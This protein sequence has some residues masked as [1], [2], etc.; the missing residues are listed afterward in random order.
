MNND[1]EQTAILGGGCFWCIEGVFQYVDGV[2]EVLSGYA[3]GDMP[4]PD[5]KSVCTGRTGHAEV[6]RVRFDPTRVSFDHLLDVFFTIHDPTQ[7]NR[8]GNDVGP[9]YRSVIFC[10]DDE[11]RATAESKIRELDASGAFSNRIVT[12][13]ADPATFYPAEDY[14]QRFFEANAGQPYCEYI[15][16]PKLDKFRQ[17]FG[18]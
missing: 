1:A 8:Q 4:D 16:R 3:G 11:Q 13:I 2:I 9:Q 7:L 17:T 12:E 6:V 5:Y 15:I 18:A 14:H 10:L